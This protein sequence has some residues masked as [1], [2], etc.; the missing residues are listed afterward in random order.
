MTAQPSSFGRD[1]WPGN[2]YAGSIGPLL[3][4]QNSKMKTLN[5]KATF[6]QDA[7]QYMQYNMELKGQADAYK[8]KVDA[9]NT[10][11]D[12]YNMKLKEE[13]DRMADIFKS[14]MSPKVKVPARPCPPSYR[15]MGNTRYDPAILQNGLAS[16]PTPWPTSALTDA[17]K[18]SLT[19]ADFSNMS[20][21][22]MKMEQQTANQNRGI[23]TGTLVGTYTSGD[24]DAASVG[25][26]W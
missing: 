15:P 14:I 10:K 26:H 6:L 7:G 20:D 21:K 11:K 18:K 8:M 2:S 25:A 22:Y 5:P 1:F 4:F 13:K 12:D 9:Y 24:V 23:R 19:L 17:T 3:S 16:S